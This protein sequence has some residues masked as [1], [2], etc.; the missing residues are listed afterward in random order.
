MCVGEHNDDVL[1]KNFCLLL[2]DKALRLDDS[3]RIMDCSINEQERKKCLAIVGLFGRA[4]SEVGAR[5]IKLAVPDQ[6]LFAMSVENSG[7]CLGSDRRLAG[8]PLRPTLFKT[9]PPAAVADKTTVDG[10]RTIRL[11]RSL[12]AVQIEH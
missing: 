9:H 5:E 4:L 11:R 2:N 7:R 10:E 3:N 1:V 6:D 8:R 12:S